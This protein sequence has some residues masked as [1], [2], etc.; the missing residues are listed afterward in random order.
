MNELRRGPWAPN[1]MNYDPCQDLDFD[2]RMPSAENAAM[3]FLDY[4]NSYEF[5]YR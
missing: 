5:I 2:F 1:E 4:R 3:P